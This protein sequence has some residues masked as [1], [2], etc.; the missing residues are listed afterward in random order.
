MKTSV[1]GCGAI[2]G[3]VA[4]SLAAGEVPGAELVGVVHGDETDPVDLPVR[5]TES[6]V[7]GADLVIECAGQGALR[8]L[9]PR[10]AD[11][12][13]DLL[14]TS[15]GALADD[16]LFAAVTGMPQ[17]RVRLAT[18]AVGGLDMLSAA[19]RMGPLHTVRL[20]TTKTAGNLVQPW[21]DDGEAERLRAATGPVELLRG[22][23]RKVTAAFPKST[24]VAASVALAVGSWDTVEAVVVGDPHAERTSHVITAEGPAGS[25]RFEITNQPSERTPTSSGVVPFAVLRAIET[26]A[27]AQAVFV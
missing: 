8:S 17:G 18:G 10:V 1:I 16:E 9:V 23:A 7:H 20:V 21:M 26:L 3:V 25:Y 22:P 6:A 12:G 19:R 15:V 14:I 2:G 5:D 27:G 11:T 4:R 13:T 24:N